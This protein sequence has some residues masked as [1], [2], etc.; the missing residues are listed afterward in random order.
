MCGY[1]DHTDN[2]ISSS[3]EEYLLKNK[4]KMGASIKV[5]P[6]TTLCGQLLATETT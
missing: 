1:C 5:M 2:S 6:C 4:K 3:K